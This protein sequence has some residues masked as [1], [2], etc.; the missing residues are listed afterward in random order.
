MKVTGVLVELLVKL[1][2]NVYGPFV[3]F[4]NRK[5]VIYLQVLRA[6]YGM[7]VVALLWYKT[8]RKDLEQIGFK[9]N[10]YDPCVCNRAIKKQQQTVRFHVDELMSSHVDKGVNDEFFKWLN[11]KYGGH[12]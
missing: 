10:P 1:A 8:L 3:V 7:L 5:K 12:G 6:L 4:K 2:P 9:F 11:K